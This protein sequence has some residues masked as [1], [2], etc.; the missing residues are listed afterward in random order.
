MSIG[1][2]HINKYQ[3]ATGI[4]ILFHSIG[5]I[6][7]L[8]FNQD[9]FIRS[10]PYNLLLSFALLTWTQENKNLYFYTFL[11]ASC[12]IGF[13]VEVIGVNT[14]L[15]FGNYKYGTVLGIQW[16]QVPLLI[17]INW[18]II[19]YCCGIST[20]TLLQK[21]IHS[22][23]GENVKPSK[24]MQALS[25]MTD[26]ATLAVLFDWLMEPV[27][28]KLGFWQWLGDGEIPLYNYLCWFLV[29][30]LLMLI[31]HVC[32]FS[33][34]NKFAVNLLLIQSMFFLLLRTFLK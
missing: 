33:K 27:A 30:I 12:V 25:V 2:T 32:R 6:G 13:F 19:L 16:Q 7:I 14:G 10:T 17:G 11:A 20:Q 21:V 18:F 15:L 1:S 8:F 9:F 24:I 26:A 23:G 3:I 5:V 4:A 31:F 29:S 22:V 28:V 34:A